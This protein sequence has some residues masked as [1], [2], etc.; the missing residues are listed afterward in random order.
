MIAP[1]NQAPD[2]AKLFCAYIGSSKTALI[3]YWLSLQFTVC[4]HLGLA[5]F[6]VFFFFCLYVCRPQFIKSAKRCIVK[7]WRTTSF[8]GTTLT[9]S[10][11]GNKSRWIIYGQ[12]Q[13]CGSPLPAHL[14]HGAGPTACSQV[15]G[16]PPVTE[17]RVRVCARGRRR[18]LWL[19]SRHCGCQAIHQEMQVEL[20]SLHAGEIQQ[21]RLSEGPHWGW[22]K[23]VLFFIVIIHFLMFCLFLLFWC[24]NFI[25]GFWPRLL[26]VPCRRWCWVSTKRKR[27]FPTPSSQISPPLS[28]LTFTP[29]S[30]TPVWPRAWWDAFFLLSRPTV[31]PSSLLIITSFF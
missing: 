29:R 31:G 20:D 18:D 21:A 30:L 10:E 6:P 7:E 5:V 16:R 8:R 28:R 26:P 9:L 23:F 2:T 15:G 13:F 22:G 17:F 4:V 19:R 24:C 14:S 1:G 11:T 3:L 12:R 27:A 25:F